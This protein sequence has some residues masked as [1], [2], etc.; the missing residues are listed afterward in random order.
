MPLWAFVGCCVPCG[1]ALQEV[2]EAT[3]WFVS[4]QPV[5][6]FYHT[7]QEE[8]LLQHVVG[9]EKVHIVELGTAMLP[10]WSKMLSLFM[11]HQGAAPMELTLS[12][13][14][15]TPL[16][17]PRRR[18]LKGLLGAKW[19]EDQLKQEA[20]RL[21][22][23]FKFQRIELQD[24]ALDSLRKQV[25]REGDE[26]ILF[27]TSFNLMHIPGTPSQG[28]EASARDSLLQV[29]EVAAFCAPL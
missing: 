13:I 9:K 28:R 8:V 27:C 17:H 25:R 4:A 21:N 22:V 18:S 23:N 15:L 29:N 6:P 11:A 7:V 14:D 26:T 24:R 2:L 20:K 5:V 3:Q 10:H 19:L 16:L 1:V 12:I